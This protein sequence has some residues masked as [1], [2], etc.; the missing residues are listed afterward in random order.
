MRSE[1][2]ADVLP[3]SVLNALHHK[4]IIFGHQSVGENLIDGI[5][6][7]YSENSSI[8]KPLFISIEQETNFDSTG[9]YHFHA[10][11]NRDPILK[12]EHFKETL[13]KG[14]FENFD[15]AFLKL[16]YVDLNIGN[17]AQINKIFETYQ[18]AVKEITSKYPGLK[19]I[20]CTVPLRTRS[21]YSKGKLASIKRLISGVTG[22]HINDA[23]NRVKE[24]YN[25]KIRETF[26]NDPIFDIAEYE[27]TTPDGKRIRFKN[28]QV[29]AFALDNYY[30]DDGGHLNTAGQK[31]LSTK[32]LILLTSL[33]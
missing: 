10:G 22:K 24:I 21:N 15:I 27:S 2:L 8:K 33:K 19:L 26:K 32:L 30:T 18:N 11:K 20:H 23:D 6:M 13:L 29:E 4:K 14:D 12:I 7:V 5:K 17:E 3:D 1:S 31:Y 25:T 16:C 9:F 28:N